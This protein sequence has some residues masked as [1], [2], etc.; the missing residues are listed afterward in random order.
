MN[1][2]LMLTAKNGELL[3]LKDLKL[4][5]TV[6]DEPLHIEWHRRLQKH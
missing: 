5:S 4:A 1:S 6:S 3:E 2:K